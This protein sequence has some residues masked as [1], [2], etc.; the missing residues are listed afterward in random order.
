MFRSSSRLGSVPPAGVP[1][2]VLS[3]SSSRVQ[4]GRVGCPSGVWAHK[5]GPCRMWSG[6]RTHA[7]HTGCSP[8]ARERL[9]VAATWHVCLTDRGRVWTSHV[10]RGRPDRENSRGEAPAACLL[11]PRHSRD[12]DRHTAVS[13][14]STQTKVALRRPQ[15]E[16]GVESAGDRPKRSAWEWA[17]RGMQERPLLPP[18]L[19][20]EMTPR[21]G[22]EPV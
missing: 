11:F 6:P 17:G 19:W 12:R 9:R 1:E 18:G 20:W 7:G 8:G 10:G 3:P 4:A 14:R 21:I 15:R 13:L 5:S 16:Q 2:L 22:K